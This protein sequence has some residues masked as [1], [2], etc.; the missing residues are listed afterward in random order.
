MVQQTIGKMPLEARQQLFDK[1]RQFGYPD[2]IINNIQQM[3]SN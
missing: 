2:E 1:A 3:L